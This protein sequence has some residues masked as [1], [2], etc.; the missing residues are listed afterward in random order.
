MWRVKF[1]FKHYTLLSHWTFSTLGN[2]TCEKNKKK[3]LQ[4]LCV[5]WQPLFIAIR[6]TQGHA[7]RCHFCPF[8]DIFHANFTLREKKIKSCACNTGGS[9]SGGKKLH[10]SFPIPNSICLKAYQRSKVWTVESGSNTHHLMDPNIGHKHWL[11]VS[12][13][14]RFIRGKLTQ[15]PKYICQ[16]YEWNKNQILISLDKN[17]SL[18]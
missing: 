9:D 15:G 14:R 6:Q 17:L 5:I 11:W 8:F 3:K 4:S 1:D 10:R 12:P 18:F 2:C 16:T 7:R 13:A